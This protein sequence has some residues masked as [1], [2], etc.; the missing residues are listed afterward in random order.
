MQNGV[1]ITLDQMIRALVLGT[2]YN[3]PRFGQQA[4]RYARRITIRFAADL[5]DDFHEEVVHEALA[6]LMEIDAA[7]LAHRSGLSLFRRAVINAI[8]T[9]R[10]NYAPP[11]RR[12][13]LM[14]KPMSPTVAADAVDQIPTKRQVGQATVIVGDMP[15]IDVD[16]FADPRSDGPIRQFE[17]ARDADRIM[18]A[19]PA[20]L[21]RVLQL[22]YFDEVP[23]QAVAAQ[24]HLSRFA[25]HRRI[26]N[27]ARPWRLAA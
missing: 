1:S 14:G 17:C 18:A 19:A 2:P 21:R 10:A 24:L 12:T 20:S 7:A 5:P 4:D 8:R 23:A 22:V 15:M 13:R 9:I 27:F 3:N 25:L 11:G 6:D 16:A 26:E